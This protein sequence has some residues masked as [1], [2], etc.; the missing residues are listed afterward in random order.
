M[1]FRRKRN[2]P[3]RFYFRVFRAFRGRK[4]IGFISVVTP[5]DY[6]FWRLRHEH[7]PA[8]YDFPQ[9]KKSTALVLFRA[10]S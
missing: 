7:P 6:L 8:V 1:I 4:C 9:E 3:H 2:P 10:N 5:A